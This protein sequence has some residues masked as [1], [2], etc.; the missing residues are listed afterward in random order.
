M[1]VAST[2]DVLIV[3]AGPAGTAA[4]WSLAR[5]GLH[6]VMADQQSFPR[7]K[8]CGDA[9]IPDALG[10]IDT[11]GLRTIIDAEAFRLPELRVYAPSGTYIALAG[12]FCCFPRARFDELLV[13]TACESGATLLERMT[14]VAP[15]VHGDRVIGARFTSP[16]GNAEIRA[17][18]TLLAT[19]ANATTM[20]AFGLDPPLKPNAVAGRAYFDVP[21]RLASTFQHLCIA[22][23]RSLCP[24]YG[25]IF[26]GPNRRFNMGV[27]FFSNGRRHLPSLRD[28]WTR[29]TSNFE[30][31]AAIL[32]ES[33]QV[34]EFRGAPLRTGL[35][36][37]TFGRPGLLA[38]GE[39]AATTYAATGEGIGKAME[40][41]LLAARMVSDA[42]SSGRPP[43]EIHTAYEAEFRRRHGARYRAYAIGQACSSH[44]WLVN[45]L[46]WRANS[47]RFVQSELQGLVSERG[48]ARRL[49]SLRGLITSLFA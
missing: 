23:E 9:L 44:P 34:A 24:G 16:S 36:G 25:W 26:P 46:A 6:V 49:L 19:G 1:A 2:C 33:T 30:P 10:A 11:M 39:S 43:S 13:R 15:L 40:S 27:G 42:V 7:D 18:M 29:F 47:G 31:A 48:D 28:L 38:V 14:A 4:A 41:G 45:Y 20:T 5:A 12:D 37:K 32:R 3:G 8:V 21:D 22:Y 35:A 17:S